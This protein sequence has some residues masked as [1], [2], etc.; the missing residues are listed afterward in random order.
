M[1]RVRPLANLSETFQPQCPVRGCSLLAHWTITTRVARRG[2]DNP[3][4]MWRCQVHARKWA[5]RHGLT[6]PPVLEPRP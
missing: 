5:E 4:S 2:L 1:P 3:R 6:F